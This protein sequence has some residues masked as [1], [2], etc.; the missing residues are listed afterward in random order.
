MCD[1]CNEHEQEYLPHDLEIEKSTTRA[2]YVVHFTYEKHEDH[3]GTSLLYIVHDMQVGASCSTICPV[4][5]NK[6]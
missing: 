4:S 3:L 2:M 1:H 5:R 6:V